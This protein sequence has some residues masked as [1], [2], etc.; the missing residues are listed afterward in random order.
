MSEGV[1]VTAFHCKWSS[2]K[3]NS[4]SYTGRIK[5]PSQYFDTFYEIFLEDDR[6]IE[7]RDSIIAHLATTYFGCTLVFTTDRCRIWFLSQIVSQQ[8]NRARKFI[9]EFGCLPFLS[10]LPQILGLADEQSWESLRE[11]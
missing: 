3:G 8:M 10:F 5:P 7:K 11:G 6:T 1:T 2:K 9:L 4:F